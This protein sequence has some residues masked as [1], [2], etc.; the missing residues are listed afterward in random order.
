MKGFSRKLYEAKMFLFEARVQACQS[1]EGTRWRRDSGSREILGE[2]NAMTPSTT[3]TQLHLCHSFAHVLCSRI[4]RCWVLPPHHTCERGTPR[5]CPE[6][7]V[8]CNNVA[9]A[10]YW[11][12]ITVDDTHPHGC[13]YGDE[14]PT[15]WGDIC[16]KKSRPGSSAPPLCL[17]RPLPPVSPSCPT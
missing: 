16:M 10:I 7:R 14:S 4:S 2:R 6:K 9:M 11:A 13:R 1:G 17:P 15:T 12:V 8:P 3:P 5:P